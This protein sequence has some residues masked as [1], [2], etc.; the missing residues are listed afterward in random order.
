MPNFSCSTFDYGAE[1]IRGAGSVRNDVMLRRDRTTLSLTPSTIVMSS[2]LAG[3]EM[4]TFFTVPR[5]C[6]DALAL[7][8]NRPVDSI[9]IWAPTELQSMRRRIFFGEDFDAA[10]ADYDVIAIHGDGLGQAA[11]QGVVFRQV[12]EGFGVGEI[13]H[14]DEFDFRVIE[15]GADDVAA[16]AAEAV[17]TNFHGHVAGGSP[18]DL[19]CCVG[20]K[21][22]DN[23]RGVLG[24]GGVRRAVRDV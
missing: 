24:D 11:E 6:F 21:E 12:S 19:R 10:G 4:M 1:A 8:T 23:K 14:G 9:T 20:I 5:R 16:Y 17:D 13:V 22:Q 3:A 18:W 2:S 7:S 15:G